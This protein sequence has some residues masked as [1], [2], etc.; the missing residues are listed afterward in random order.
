MK[1]RL[2]VLMVN[3]KLAKSREKAKEMIKAGNVYV[4]KKQVQKA[5]T[6]SRCSF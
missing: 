2:D 4:D 1:E 6:K 5:S 3:R